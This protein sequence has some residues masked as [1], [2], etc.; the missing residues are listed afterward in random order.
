MVGTILAA[1]QCFLTL[2]ALGL[3]FGPDT[4]PWFRGRRV[5]VDPEIFR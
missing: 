1:A 2:F 5:P 3:I 4:G